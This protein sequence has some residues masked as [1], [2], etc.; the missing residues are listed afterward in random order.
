M[1]IDPAQL[2]MSSLTSISEKPA[3]KGTGA[4]SFGQSLMNAL[5]EVNSAQTHASE[6]STRFAAGEGIDVHEVMIASQ[7][8]GVMLSLATQV[9]NK[10]V[11]GFQEIMRTNI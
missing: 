8:A 5:G 1:R 9:R 6:I 2:D 4:T 7:E 10:V 11:D 3:T